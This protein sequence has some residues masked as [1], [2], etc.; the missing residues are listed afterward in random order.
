[1]NRFIVTGVGRSGTKFCSNLFTALGYPCG[2]ERLYTPQTQ[3]P[4]PSDLRGDS[5]WMAAPHLPK[6]DGTVIHLV[7]HPLLVARTTVR[8]LERALDRNNTQRRTDLFYPYLT[9]YMPSTG[10]AHIDFLRY[11]VGWNRMI[12]PYAHIRINI[13]TI[14]PTVVQQA[15]ALIG[16]PPP[17]ERIESVLHRPPSQWLNHRPGIG[18]TWDDFPDRSLVAQAQA[19]AAGYGYETEPRDGWEPMVST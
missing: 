11:W 15:C 18:V 6:F 1:M 10:D 14:G 9:G 13:E 16:D 8:W 19:L 17:L 5:S 7:R 2:H 3:H 4:F 12:E